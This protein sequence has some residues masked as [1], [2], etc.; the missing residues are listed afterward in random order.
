MQI[1]IV[2]VEIEEAIIE[3]IKRQIT[4]NADQEITVDLR[5]TR[6]AE[7]YQAI[8]DIRPK[9]DGG[10]GGGGNTPAPRPSPAPESRDE[11]PA[12]KA[13]PIE[14]KVTAPQP[15]KA[16]KA[17]AKAP[18][19]VAKAP[20]AAIELPEPTIDVPADCT[21]QM[22]TPPEVVEAVSA[23]ASAQDVAAVREEEA[24]ASPTKPILFKNATVEENVPPPANPGRSIFASMKKPV[25]A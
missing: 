24:P 7:G 11:R 1:T 8:I 3:H 6:G 15:S 20:A 13:D 22:E 14:A 23:E 21:P 19:P 18:A 5:A 2:Q 9:R 16:P 4:I 17:V 10:N 25:N 12:P